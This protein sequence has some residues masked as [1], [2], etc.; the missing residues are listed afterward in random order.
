MASTK[1]DETTDANEQET[2]VIRQ[3]RG[4]A[5]Q[6]LSCGSGLRVRDQVPAT[7]KP[8]VSD[9]WSDSLCVFRQTKRE[10]AGNCASGPQKCRDMRQV[11]RLLH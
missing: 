8:L 1:I 5:Q 10:L 6:V 7:A 9:Y 11:H 2:C 4:N 3:L